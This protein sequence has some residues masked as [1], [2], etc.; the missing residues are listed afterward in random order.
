MINDRVD[1]VIKELFEMLLSRYQIGLETLTRSS[2]FIFDYIDSSYC[3]C[4]KINLIYI[5]LPR[6][7][8]TEQ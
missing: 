7:K 6:Y 3:K 8:L 5:L 4:H 2:D 1:K